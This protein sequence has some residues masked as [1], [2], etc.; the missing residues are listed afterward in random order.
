[1]YDAHRVLDMRAR[2]EE[3]VSTQN[4]ARVDGPFKPS[5]ADSLLDAAPRSSD[6]GSG[7]RQRVIT[8]H[9]IRSPASRG[10]EETAHALGQVE[11]TDTEAIVLA[12]GFRSE[13]D[14]RK[15]RERL[16]N[17]NGGDLQNEKAGE[18]PSYMFDRPVELWSKMQA[19]LTRVY[20]LR[21]KQHAC[22]TFKV[23]TAEGLHKEGGRRA[24]IMNKT[25]F[26]HILKK[27][28]HGPDMKN[29]YDTRF[30]IGDPGNNAL[31]FRYDI[32]LSHSVYLPPSFKR[33]QIEYPTPSADEVR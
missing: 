10:R 19:E 21:E 2:V 26:L 33:S 23:G 8:F 4:P 31:I 5:T 18:D 9:C 7:T 17:K 16:R 12:V 27:A 28:H 20:R 30:F 1:M 25:Q 24:V 3:S 6:H 29:D 14:I 22:F 11:Q 13:M 15:A 32:A